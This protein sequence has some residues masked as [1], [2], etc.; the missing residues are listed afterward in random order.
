MDDGELI[1]SE[2]RKPRDLLLKIVAEFL[3]KSTSRLSDLSKKIP[4]LHQKNSFCEL[5]DIKCHLRLAEIAHSLLKLAPYDPQTMAS[6]GLVRYMNEILPNS[7]WRQE[8]MRP[9]LIMVLRRLDKTFTKISKKSGIKR[10]TDWEA[11]KLLLK[12]VYLTFIKHPYIV[13]LPHL[14]SLISVCQ[15]IILGDQIYNLSDSSFSTFSSWTVALSQ[16]PPSGFTSVAVRLISLQ[17]LQ[18]GDSQTLETLCSGAFASFEKSEI[19]LMNMIY[20]LCIRATSGIKYIPKLRQCDIN[21]VLSVILNI[22]KPIQNKSNTLKGSDSSHIS[23]QLKQFSLQQIGFLGLK[24]LITCFEKQLTTEW[25]RIAKCIRDLANKPQLISITFW[26]FLDF[27]TTYR[28][29][30]FILTIPY[31]KCKYINKQCD[32]EIDMTYR[33][34]ICEKL[35]GIGTPLN[36][37]KGA[38]FVS[39]VTELKNLRDELIRF[40]NNPHI[41]ERS[42]SIIQEPNSS[43][44]MDKPETSTHRLSFALSQLAASASKLSQIS[45]SNSN[46][47]V[48]NTLNINNEA[49]TTSPTHSTKS[50]LLRGLSF[51]LSTDSRRLATRGLSVK[52]TSNQ[53]D[54]RMYTRRTSYPD[55]SDFAIKT[56]GT[57]RY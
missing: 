32:N 2:F 52:M 3:S 22:L 49:P 12:G 29:P 9:A 38:L 31:I 6:K 47:A 55:H 26:N 45:S 43:G 48:V 51:K 54:K 53:A 10:Q 20:P 8:K 42:R 25:Y 14:K 27:I 41:D 4:D 34:K 17:M 46:N 13:H 23:N 36:R 30:L 57:S 21:F 7:E 37:S 40:K 19:Y 1:R 39:L 16:A 11:A 5:L 50:G 24:I 28:T 35:N 18:L 56:H 15:N 33:T 44:T